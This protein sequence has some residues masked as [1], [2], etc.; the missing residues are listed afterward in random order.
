METHKRLGCKNS[1]P[2]SLDLGCTFMRTVRP[3]SGIADLRR[4]F[5]VYSMIR[6]PAPLSVYLLLWPW[7]ISQPVS[8][9]DTYHHSSMARTLISSDNLSPL[10]LIITW[11]LCIISVLCMGARGATKFIFT[12]SIKSDDYSSLA[13]LV[14]STLDP[15]QGLN[16]ADPNILNQ[17]SQYCSVHCCHSTNLKWAGQTCHR[18]GCCSNI[19]LLKGERTIP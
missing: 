7:I 13:S 17:V 3:L 12:R 16:L 6:S 5:I 4:S 15:K 10:V 8:F 1:Y 14:I 2:S 9:S 11:F 19:R 18:L